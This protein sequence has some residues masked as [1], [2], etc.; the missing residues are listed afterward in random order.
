MNSIENPH[1]FNQYRPDDIKNIFADMRIGQIRHR[2]MRIESVAPDFTLVN[3]NG[4]LINLNDTLEKGSVIL[5]FAAEYACEFG[6]LATLAN[7]QD[8]TLLIIAPHKKWLDENRHQCNLTDAEILHDVGN[9]VAN[10]YGL[11][12][13]LSND[14]HYEEFALSETDLQISSFDA[15][16]PA[17]YAI[18]SQGRIVFSHV[19]TESQFEIDMNELQ[20]TLTE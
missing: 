6:Q 3:Q 1:V 17:I 11:T 10:Q 5:G 7:E 14:R 12:Q 9:Y 18:D 8:A 16:V 15:P 4:D 13:F 19:K 2:M 20:A